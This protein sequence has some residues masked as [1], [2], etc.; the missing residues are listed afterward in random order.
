MYHYFNH[1]TL[2]VSISDIIGILTLLLTWLAVWLAY[3]IWQKQ[4]NINKEQHWFNML[5]LWITEYRKNKEKQISL[6]KEMGKYSSKEKIK[7]DLK[8]LNDSS[9]E[10][11]DRFDE[12]L[13]YYIWDTFNE[14]HLEK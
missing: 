2:Y 10:M 14:I 11:E 13:D 5:V 7:A 1:Q 12:L 9:K 3:R 8:I 4:I 6:I